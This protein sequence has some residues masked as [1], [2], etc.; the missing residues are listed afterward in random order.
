MIS[1]GKGSPNSIHHHIAFKTSTTLVIEIYYKQSIQPKCHINIYI[2]SSFFTGTCTGQIA[3][4]FKIATTKNTTLPARGLKSTMTDL[5][6]TPQRSISSRPLLL[7]LE[8]LLLSKAA[9]TL[10]F[11]EKGGVPGWISLMQVLL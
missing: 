11:L 8:A 7:F 2:S 6:A 3:L 1:N 9:Q 5:Y 10:F 4:L